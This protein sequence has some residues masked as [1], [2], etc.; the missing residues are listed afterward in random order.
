MV[1]DFKPGERVLLHLAGR[2]PVRATVIPHGG[3]GYEPDDVWVKTD[4][5][6]IGR[7]SCEQL[8]RVDLPPAH[9]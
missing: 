1:N 8:E 4:S 7:A 5:G 3:I 6:E 2:A 9:T